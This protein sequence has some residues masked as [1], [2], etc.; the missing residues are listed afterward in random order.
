MLRLLL[1]FSLVVLAGCAEGPEQVHEEYR[2]RLAKFLPINEAHTLTVERWPEFSAE[3][4][5]SGVRMGILELGQLGHCQLATDIA[6][7]NNQLGKVATASERFKYHLRFLQQ[8]NACLNHPDSE[9][10]SPS[11]IAALEQE[12]QFKTRTLGQAFNNLLAQ[13]KE[14]KHLFTFSRNALD[15]DEQAGRVNSQSALTQLA[16]IADN[17]AQHN[18]EDIDTEQLTQ[19]LEQLNRS[20]YIAK[21]LRATRE[22]IALNNAL[23]AELERIKL[24]G[25]I[26]AAHKNNRNSMIVHNIFN[27]FYI[28]QLQGFQSHLAGRLQQLQPI[29]TRILQFQPDDSHIKVQLLGTHGEP[30]LLA[31]LKTSSRRHV[32]WWQAFYKHCDLT[33]GE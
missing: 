22:Q 29:F 19:A 21:L 16:N 14:L 9:T 7:R 18:V 20:D 12:K 33:P 10:L 15:F 31:E 26:C 8:V 2:A 6:G 23:S 32:T 4:L 28:G 3:P 11:L 5:D 17:L 1:I 30:S 13:E 27:K 25:D 24:P